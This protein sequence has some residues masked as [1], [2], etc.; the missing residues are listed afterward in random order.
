M[1]GKLI[2]ERLTQGIVI[3]NDENLFGGGHCQSFVDYGTLDNSRMINDL[4]I[5]R[6]QDNRP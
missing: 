3:V 4:L 2:P 1:Q 5:A 6:G